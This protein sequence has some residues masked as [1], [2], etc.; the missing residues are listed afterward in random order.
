MGLF[1]KTDDK[2]RK[3]AAKAGISV[4]GA[5]YV[6]QGSE[7]SRTTYLVVHPD[8]VELHRGGKWGALTQSGAGNQVV[9]IA[10]ASSV[11][12]RR[13]GIWQVVTVYTSG[14]DL[15]FRCDIKT[16]TAAEDAVRSV[17]G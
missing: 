14:T 15:E 5:V 16:G 3:K 9:P 1:K 17:L 11:A 4:D 12:S 7:D 13:D 8:R 2:A 6:G 10:K